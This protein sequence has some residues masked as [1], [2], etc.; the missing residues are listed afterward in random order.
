MLSLVD[1]TERHIAHLPDAPEAPIAA[2]VDAGIIERMAAMEA[3]AREVLLERMDK[4]PKNNKPVDQWGVSEDAVLGDV[5]F[6]E[7]EHE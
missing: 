5:T 1:E 3:A 4:K 6:L 7:E 2:T